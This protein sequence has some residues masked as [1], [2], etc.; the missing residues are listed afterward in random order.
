MKKSHFWTSHVY[1]PLGGIMRVITTPQ[2][3]KKKKK[4]SNYNTH[5]CDFYTHSVI[6]HAECHF[7]TPHTHECNF[8]TKSAISTRRV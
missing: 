4:I 5:E 2:E 8:D 7:H 3:S 1:P 6:I